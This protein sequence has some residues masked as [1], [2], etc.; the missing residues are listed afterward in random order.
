MVEDSP[1]SADMGTIEQVCGGIP[2]AAIGIPRRYTHSP[3]EVISLDYLS[4]TVKILQKVITILDAGYSLDR[5]V[6]YIQKHK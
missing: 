2:S 4:N 5:A 3:N 6:S 1:G